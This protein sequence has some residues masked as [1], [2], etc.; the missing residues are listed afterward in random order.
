MPDFGFSLEDTGRLATVLLGRSNLIPSS[1]KIPKQVTSLAPPT[2]E[3]G[4]IFERYK[5]LTCHEFGEQGG[6]LAPDLAFEG[7]KVQKEW[8]KGYLK[9]PYAIRP[10]LVERM[11][12]FNMTPQ[13]ADRLAV[14]IDLV[15]RN[16]EVDA[17]SNSQTGNPDT[18]R[19]LY[20]DKYICQSCHSIDGEGGYYGPALENVANR[21]KPTWLNTRLVSPH[22]YEPDAREPAL[23]IPDEDR[24]N[25]L[26]FLNIL[27][28]E[29]QP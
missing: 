20:F 9:K 27:K 17:A 28:V 7:S 16:D 25:I 26:A 6:T 11:P 4:K 2:G 29:E 10:Y 18:G 5:C 14:Y 1:Y 3:V 19:S 8:L 21:L 13:E 22:S 23:N 24:K 12:R 15:L